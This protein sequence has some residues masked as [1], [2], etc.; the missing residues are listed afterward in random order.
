MSATSRYS[1]T[2]ELR[3]DMCCGTGEVSGVSVDQLTALDAYGLPVI[4][5]KRLKG[6]LRELAVLI[7]LPEQRGFTDALFGVSGSELAGKL[8]FGDARLVG[9]R[10]IK[11]IVDRD[12]LMPDVVAAVYTTTR[13]TTSVE[14]DGVA[15]DHTL[16]TMQLVRR[17]NTSG[18]PTRFECM[19]RGVDLT[20][21]EKDFFD[22]V[23]R[24]LRAI[25]LKKSRGLGEVSCRGSW[26]DEVANEQAGGMGEPARADETGLVRR[27]YRIVLREPAAIQGVGGSLDYLPGA[28]VQGVFAS[29]FRSDEDFLVNHVLKGTRFSNAYVDVS[30]VE[31]L[32]TAPVPFTY[33]G[34]KNDMGVVDAATHTRTYKLFDASVPTDAAAGDDAVQKVGILG[35]G[36]H[37]DG[38]YRVA[39]VDQ[40]MSFHSSSASSPQGKQYYSMRALDAGQSFSGTIE[41]VPAAMARFEAALVAHGD[42]LR[43]GAAGSAGFGGCS[44]EFLP[45]RKPSTLVVAPGDRVAIQLVSDVV[46]VDECGTN[47]VDA[48]A[49]AQALRASGV[50]G[51]DF[52]A[53]MDA[54]EGSDS[55]RSYVRNCV[56]GGYN[57]HW[58]L[59]KRQYVAFQK[60]SVLV[61]TVCGTE[62]RSVLSQAWTGLLQQ[63]GCGQ[64]VV[65]KLEG[66]AVPGTFVKVR[67]ACVSAGSSEDAAGRHAAESF[68][69][70]LAFNEARERAAFVACELGDA[71]PLGAASKSSFMRVGSVFASAQ[72]TAGVGRQQEAFRS[73]ARDVLADDEQLKGQ[74]AKVANASEE[75]LADYDQLS[76]ACRDA[77]F[78]QVVRGYLHQAKI[79]YSNQQGGS[80]E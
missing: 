77:V 48:V 5:A 29:M 40:S 66:D 59:P 10:Q 30:G 63:E 56:V 46:F 76:A 33:Q 49:F 14:E 9:H 67:P 61:A 25:G 23:V 70:D 12:S 2:I 50:L 28:V 69:H 36:V 44:L 21:P 35:Y 55:C 31:A 42:N 80:H 37:A 79:R 41:A 11:G 45:E 8:S 43:V 22:D 78:A 75:L 60:G 27:G 64:L 73:L 68:A 58:R 74:C 53:S 7:E 19:V 13:T 1:M 54:G 3:S 18:E 38:S 15:A 34:N 51:F 71:Y 39:K 65:R 62:A 72:K 16:H 24:C 4:P 57:A 17:C 47:S 20:E 6:L 32:P 52:D 26:S